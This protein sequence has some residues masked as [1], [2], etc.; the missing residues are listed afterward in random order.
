M[1]SRQLRLLRGAAASTVATVTA[2][3]SHTVGGGAPPHPLLVLSLSVFLT[4]VAA[5]LV[6]RTPRISRLSAAVLASQGVFHTLFTALG[7]T[8]TSGVSTG[9]HQHFLTLPAVDS[10]L[11]AVVPDTSMLGAHLVASILTI[12]LLWRGEQLL[13]GVVRWVRAALRM[14]IPRLL[15]DFPR[16]AG[17]S[18]TGRLFVSTI[19]A[20]ELFLRGPPLLSRG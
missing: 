7:A 15:T 17:L 16:P 4:P 13:R 3:V 5:F 2:A 10:T 11:T 6:G 8:L 18:A 1:T 12:A 14:R 9:G 19:R 20:G